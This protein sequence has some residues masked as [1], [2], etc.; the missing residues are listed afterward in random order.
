M[1]QVLKISRRAYYADFLAFAI[2]YSTG[3]ERE[4]K[5]TILAQALPSKLLRRISR[6]LFD[7]QCRGENLG[8][9]NATLCVALTFATEIATIIE[10]STARRIGVATHH[11]ARLPRTIA[12][13]QPGFS[14]D[15][16]AVPRSF[17]VVRNILTE[18][19]GF[20][21]EIQNIE[22]ALRLRSSPHLKAFKARFREF[23][24]Q[25]VTGDL[26]AVRK[27]R[28]EVTA[29]RR[30]LRRAEHWDRGLRWLSYISLPAGIVE[31]LLG[32]A[33]IAGTS[34]AV[35]SAAGSAATTRMHDKNHW[36]LFGS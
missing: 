9:T 28:A 13:S 12:E 31:S 18:E 5:S 10:L 32:G 17:G 1:A 6:E 36:A 34:L 20:L 25:L 23:H 19:G 2:A 21:P 30:A 16:S 8:P 35:M 26:D 33:P 3:N 4:A 29:A 11:Y 24:S 27:I 22:H 7:F 15:P 14:T